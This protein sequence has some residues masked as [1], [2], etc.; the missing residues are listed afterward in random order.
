MTNPTEANVG[1]PLTA[2]SDGTFLLPFTTP[3]R[4]PSGEI[5]AAGVVSRGSLHINDDVEVFADGFYKATRCTQIV[6]S[7]APGIG[8]VPVNQ[9]TT[10]DRA[11]LELLGITL[12]DIVPGL[13]VANPGAMSFYSSCTVTFTNR[14][15]SA[16]L[17][18]QVLQCGFYWITS[19]RLTLPSGST[20][21]LPGETMTDVEFL[22]LRPAVVEI[23][24]GFVVRS[25]GSSGVVT[26]LG[27]P[28]NA[29]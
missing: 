28:A 15:E 20:H 24:Q 27:S 10:G 23:G 11:G 18:G 17:N 2:N 8:Y 29:P 6:T 25:N 19:T 16:V 5:Y 26:E 22:F 4:P 3:L 1:A 21:I 13:L 9:C 7:K 14:S 12:G